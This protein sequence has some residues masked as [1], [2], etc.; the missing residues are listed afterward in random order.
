M[1]LRGAQLSD[2][3]EI[4]VL[5]SQFGWNASENEIKARLEIILGRP[6]HRV[7]V[8]EGDAGE[9]LGWIHVG[10]DVIL[11]S[12]NYGEVLAFVVREGVRGSGIGGALLL[13]AEKWI[14]DHEHHPASIVIRCNSE[15]KRTHE[16]YTRN[17]YDITMIGLRKIINR[18]A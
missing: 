16:F 7:F 10:V 11:S 4:L 6:D 2:A 14:K 8:Y 18:Q 1:S 15:R 17:G 12:G 13:H 5:S 3:K 9:I